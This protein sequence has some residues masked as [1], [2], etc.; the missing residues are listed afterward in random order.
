M[1]FKNLSFKKII[2]VI[3]LG[4]TTLTLFGCNT[5][6]EEEEETLYT[7]IYDGNGGYLGNKTYTYRKLQVNEN[8]IIPKYLSEYTQD[9]YVV[10]S[11]GLATRQGY[12]LMGW[13]LEEN[14]IYNL[15]SAGRYV[16]LDTEQGNGTYLID[17]DGA[18]VYG[19]VQDDEGDLVFVKVEPL[20]ADYDPE[21]VE[22]IY[23]DGDNGY[24]FYIYDQYDSTHQAIYDNSEAYTPED[25]SSYGTTALV[26]EDLSADEQTL[27]ADLPKYKQDF[28]PYTEEDEGLDRYSFKSAYVSLE[29]IF[30]SNSQGS[31]VLDGTEYVEFDDTNPVHADLNHYE[32]DSKYKFVPTDTYVTPS[33]LERYSAEFTYWDFEND[34]VNEDLILYAHW[35]RKFTVEYVQTLSGQITYITTKQSDDNTTQVELV[36]GETIGKIGTIPTYPGHTFVGWSKSET[37]Y[38]PWDFEN[39]VF[40][41]GVTT[42][43]LYS[44]MLEGEYTRIST[45]DHLSNIVD[46][47]DGNYVLTTNL[48]LGGEIFYNEAP[49]GLEDSS[50]L[51]SVP[52]PFTGV[53]KGMGYTISN[54]V[55]T[56][57]NFQKFINA[58]S[59]EQVI[60]GLFPFVQDAEI[61]GLN[62]ETTIQFDTAPR[63]TDAIC[64]LG[65]A[66]LIGTALAG[67]TV[68]TDVNVDIVFTV[69]S[70]NTSDKPVFIGDVLA[71]G[72]DNVTLTNVTATIDYSAVTGITTDT[73]NVQTLD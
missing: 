31:F 12:Q 21:T 44:Y 36:A 70:T 20:T 18:Y 54:Y 22:Y 38:V 23:Y 16:Y 2:F 69:N 41:M 25:L 14:A 17:E 32:I 45:A 60:M 39:D 9:P 28:Y 51:G 65:G 52:V 1:N 68:V 63:G 35:E 34:R 3:L 11:L 6:G 29:S 15:D 61:S 46:N 49:T 58:N 66:G 48:D 13:Y 27:F 43:R 55:I 40:P 47:P 10:S 19:Y 59:G 5:G 7:V 73:L 50:S 57:A 53:F 4:V 26:F 64:D 62:V 56:V 24:G 37:E 30:L 33:D 42:L 72:V 67:T 71:V 8:S